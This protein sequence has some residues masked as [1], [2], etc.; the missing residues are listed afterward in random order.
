MNWQPLLGLFCFAYA[1]FVI[2]V[3]ATKK[4]ESIWEMG[5]IKMFRKFLGDKG[6][7]I[8]FIIWSILFLALG[9]W[10]FTV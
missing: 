4:P 5:K 8:F 6:T 9:I 2:Y 7:Q 10:A 3:G 1:G